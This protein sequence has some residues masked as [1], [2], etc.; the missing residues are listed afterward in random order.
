MKIVIYKDGTYTESEV[1]WEYECAEDWLVTLPLSDRNISIANHIFELTA[2]LD[3]ARKLLEDDASEEA[4]Y[5]RALERFGAASQLAMAQE[6][7]AELIAAI[8]H[9]RRRNSIEELL[10]EIA[11]VEIMLGQLRLML[12]DAAID[13]RKKAKLERLAQRLEGAEQ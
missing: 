3:E 1:T 13:A 5:K 10:G 7:C 2:H 8:S 11:D 9:L 12:G 6:E 4:I